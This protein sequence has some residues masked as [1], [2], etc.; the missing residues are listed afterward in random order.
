MFDSSEVSEPLT[1]W[2]KN[3]LRAGCS[4]GFL[5]LEHKSSGFGGVPARND[6]KLNHLWITLNFGEVQLYPVLRGS[7]QNNCPGPHTT[8]ALAKLSCL[9]FGF[10]PGGSGAWTSA[11]YPGSQ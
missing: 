11:F 8:G 2:V 5:L 10:S 9:D 6:P 4:V 1:N 3:L 7:K